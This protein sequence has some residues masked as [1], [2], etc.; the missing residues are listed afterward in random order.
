[1]SDDR[2]DPE[3][4]AAFLEGTQS[5]AE[6]ERVRHTLL[7]SPQSFDAFLELAALDRTM[8]S[9][10]ARVEPRRRFGRTWQIIGPMLVAAGLTGVVILAW[11]PPWRRADRTPA[12]STPQLAQSS[13]LIGVSGPGSVR[14]ALGPSWSE[15]GWSV[16]RG[17]DAAL[18]ARARAFRAGARCAEVEVAAQAGDPD[19]L[20]LA[21]ASLLELLA[22]VN[23]GAPISRA[24]RA[25][26]ATADP[27]GRAARLAT[28]LQLRK[29]LGSDAWFD[30]GM[31]VET[32]RLALLARQLEFFAAT[33]PGVNDLRRILSALDASTVAD[34]ANAAAAADRLRI[35]VES[36]NWSVD[37]VDA[38]SA[39][40]RSTIALAAH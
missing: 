29:L 35:F 17:G 9:G 10:A 4:L 8:D 33:G 15:P 32:A 16:A 3:T 31:W 1:V 25:L 27:G 37:D 22:G 28:V 6:R 14:V 36:R 12:A 40:L 19:A 39:A 2:I 30:L 18:S 24:F 26:S 34:R 7:R 38:M 21:T 5:P 20:M 13:A 23:A 11:P